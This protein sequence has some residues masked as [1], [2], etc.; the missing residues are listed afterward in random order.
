M[1]EDK[2]MTNCKGFVRK[3]LSPNLRYYPGIC[4]EGMRKTTK[5]SPRMAGLWAEI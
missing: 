2:C 1:K 3:W 5:K 4:L